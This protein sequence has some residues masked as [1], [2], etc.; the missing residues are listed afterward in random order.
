M[1]PLN[2]LSGGSFGDCEL[3]DTDLVLS[4]GL[5]CAL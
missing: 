4:A 2:H 3:S 1:E 5:I